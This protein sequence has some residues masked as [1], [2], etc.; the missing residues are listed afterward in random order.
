MWK[1]KIVCV[2]SITE[3][4]FCDVAKQRAAFHI[5]LEMLQLEIQEYA[6]FISRILNVMNV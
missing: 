2:K 3:G 1:V 6:L 5:S 4:E